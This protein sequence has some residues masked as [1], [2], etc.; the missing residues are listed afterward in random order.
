MIITAWSGVLPKGKIQAGAA[1]A[2]DMAGNHSQVILAAQR[3]KKCFISFF[4]AFDVAVG[5][6]SH[7]VPL[8]VSD[9]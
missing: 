4:Y 1:R 7:F 3:L 6:F 9:Q 8:S 5:Y 2:F